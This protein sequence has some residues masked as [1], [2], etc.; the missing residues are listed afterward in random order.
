MMPVSVFIIALNEADR[1]G[2]TLASVHPIADEIIVI[3]SGSTDGTAE[4]C[5]R[6]GATVVPHAW[7]GYGPQKR[8]GETQCRNDWVLNLD[9]DEVLSPALTDALRTL[10]FSADG[11]RLSIADALPGEPLP[12]RFA[13]TT[14]AVRL[15]RKSRGSYANS[16]VHDRVHFPKDATIVALQQRVYHYSMRSVSHAIEKLNRYTTMLA[17]DLT[18]REKHIPFFYARLLTE[19]CTAFFKSYVLRG[20]I[21]RGW[22]GFINAWIYAFSRFARLA[23][24]FESR[25]NTRR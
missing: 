11:Y 22:S 24:H 25:R 10:D 3:D 14:H 8:F 13:H 5:A 9:A 7:E 2:A 20:D 16:T 19:P 4:V 17:N 1:I 12:G 21:L 23:K 18:T 15:Y 6:Y